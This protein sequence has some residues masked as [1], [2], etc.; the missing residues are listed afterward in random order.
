[1]ML[2]MRVE[3]AR[4]LE[5]TGRCKRR[6]HRGAPGEHPPRRR[7]LSGQPPGTTREHPLDIG[8]L[9]EHKGLTTRTWNVGGAKLLESLNSSGRGAF[10]E[11]GDDCTAYRSAVRHC[12]CRGGLD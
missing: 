9:T 3:A 2:P 10:R 1:M 6:D 7:R 8:T 5:S 11:P 4:L 12:L